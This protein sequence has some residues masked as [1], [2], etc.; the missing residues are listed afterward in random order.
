MHIYGFLFVIDFF[1]WVWVLCREKDLDEVLQSQ[2]VYFNV[3]KGVLAKSKDLVAAFGTDD[4]AK[5]C[6]EVGYLANPFRGPFLFYLLFGFYV[7]A[8]AVG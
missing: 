8:V 3:S 2:T 7:L 1:S 5:I 6:L 4:Q